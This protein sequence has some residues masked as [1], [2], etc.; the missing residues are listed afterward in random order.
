VQVEIRRRFLTGLR[1]DA[2]YYRP[3]YNIERVE[4]LKGAN[5]LIFGRG[6]GGGVINRVSKTAGLGQNF[7]D[8]DGSVDTFGAWFVSGDAN[9]T[10]NDDIAVRLTSIYEEFDNHRD[11]FDG[12]FFGINPTATFAPGDDTKIVVSYSY[13]DD[14]RVVDRG[15]PSLGGGPLRGFDST[16]FGAPEVNEASAEVHIARVRADHRF[17]EGLMVNGAVQY[18]D[19]D[20]AY[21]N[22]LPRGTD[23]ETVELSGYHDFFD[24]ENIILQGNLIWNQSFG[25]IDNVFLAGV[26]YA[27]QDTEN[28]RENILFDIGGEFVS[29]ATVPLADT[30][31]VPDTIFTPRVRDRRSDLEVFSAYVQDQID[32]GLVQLLGGVRY[33]RFELDSN[34][35]VNEFDADRVDDRFSPRGAAILKP[36]EELSVYVSY[37]ESFLPQSGDQFLVLT[38]ETTTFAPER[39]ETL[40]A[41]IKWAPN[42]RLLLSAAIFDQDRENGR[43]TDP[44]NPT[45]VVLTGRTEVQGFELQAVGDILPGWHVNVGYTYLDGEVKSQVGSAPPGTRLEQV[46]ENQVTLFTRY[47]ITDRFGI[48]GGLVHLSDQFTSL[49]NEVELPDFTRVDLAF[50]FDVVKNVALQ[51][52]IEN[53]FDEDYFASAHGDNNIQPAAPLNASFTARVR[54]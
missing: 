31:A 53:L 52:N 50:Y 22:V 36:F 44:D 30:I 37:A 20:K 46:P 38:P 18:A 10:V 32:F 14:E 48:G 3:L 19:Y 27:D 51:V 24:R 21:A 54:F 11:V 1:D 15:I 26:E 5:A 9:G 41:G 40:E 35:I 8:V 6:G 12:R 49:S 28:A 45:L 43:T 42:E 47:D 16:F 39:F 2:Q 7:V 23:G 33:E 25:S 29:R 17:A 4:V 34:D 13:D